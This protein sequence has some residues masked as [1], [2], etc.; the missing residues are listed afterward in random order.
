MT[1]ETTIAKLLMAPCSSPAFNDS[2]VPMAWEAAPKAKPFAIGSSI[3]NILKIKLETTVPKI[4]AKMTP[5]QN[6]AFRIG[7]ILLHDTYEGLMMYN[8]PWSK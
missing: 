2:A 1:P 8:K 5:I 4:P 6:L 3:L 7:L